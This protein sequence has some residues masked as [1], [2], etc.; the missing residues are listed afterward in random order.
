MA[1]LKKSYPE[2]PEYNLILQPITDIHLHSNFDGELECE[3]IFG[4]ESGHNNKIIYQIPGNITLENISIPFNSNIIK[5]ILNSNKDMEVGKLY[6]N[7]EGLMKLEFTSFFG[8]ISEYFL[9]RKAKT[10]F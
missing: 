1:G 9:V 6:L 8:I 7:G 10:E 4:D 5:N 2:I 3:F